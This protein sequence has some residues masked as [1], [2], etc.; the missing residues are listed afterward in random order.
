MKDIV[1]YCKNTIKEIGA[2][3]NFTETSLKINL[4]KEEYINIEEVIL[5]NEE[6]TK[7]TVKQKTKNK[8]RNS[9]T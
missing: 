5:Q 1:K 4:E 8:S 9:I 2:L 7:R 6:N 3:I